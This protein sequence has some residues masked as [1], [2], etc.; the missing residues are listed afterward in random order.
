MCTILPALDLKFRVDSA[1]H[2]LTKPGMWAY[3]MQL[4]L[5]S[6]YWFTFPSSI[7]F[8]SSRDLEIT[9]WVNQR[10]PNGRVSFG[11]NY[12]MWSIAL[13]QISMTAVS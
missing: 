10:D 7:A 12:A 5:Y 6:R 9:H 11:S 3:Y 4:A 2:S 13:M 1:I 8:R